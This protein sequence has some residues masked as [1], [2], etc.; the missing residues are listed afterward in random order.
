MA[1]MRSKVVLVTGATNGIGQVTAL[2]LAKMGATLVIVG[3]SPQKV[4]DTQMTIRQASGNPNVD[5]MVADLSEMAQV[6]QL[7][8]EFRRKYDRLDVLVN[9]A[10]I[11]TSQRA[12]TSE[13]FERMFA[14]NHLSYFLLTNLLLDVIKASAP[15][16]IVNVSSEAHRRVTLDFDDLQNTR[17]WGQA[18]FR[19]YG[20]TKLMNILFTRELARRLEGS[21]VTANAVHPGV[22]ATGIWRGAGGVFG[23]VVGALAPMFMKS[24]EEGAQTSIYV[25]TAPEIEGMT[26]LYFSD[27]KPAQPSAAAQDDAAARK[28]WDISAR[29]VGL[30]EV[31]AQPG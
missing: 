2:E 26:G 31:A 10:G 17:D 3:R 14:L 23:T 29:L 27:S 28:L 20:R 13:G 18:G 9:N 30:S 6:R 22:V 11:G 12:V 4:L 7:A 15:A 21:G 5:G 8:A 19:A 25:A 1:D 24:P 16:R